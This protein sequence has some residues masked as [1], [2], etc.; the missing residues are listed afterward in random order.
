MINYNSATR[1]RQGPHKFRHFEKRNKGFT[2]VIASTLAFLMVFSLFSANISSIVHLLEAFAV[3]P[4]Y[5]YAGTTSSPKYRY[6]EADLTLYD[7]KTNTE[8]KSDSNSDNNAYDGEN[9]NSVF[10]KALYES[11]YTDA[12]WNSGAS[13]RW[14]LYL[15]L[16]FPGQKQGNQMIKDSGNTYHYSIVANSEAAS[17]TSGAALG[18][19]D[20]ELHGG[21]I[22][23]GGGKV[24]L[25]YFDKEFLTAPLSS[26]LSKSTLKG[27]G[28]T[29]RSST[30][31]GSVLENQKFKFI[32]M[33]DGYYRYK[34]T[35]DALSRSGSTYT[36]GPGGTYQDDLSWSGHSARHAF[37]PWNYTSGH[38]GKFGYGAKFDIKFT[39][40]STGQTFKRD[41]NGNVVIN[42]T[43]HQP[44]Y[45]NDIK[46]TFSGDDDVWVFIDDHLVLDVGGA[47][48]EVGGE[49]CFKKG[50][51]YAKTNY[52]KTTGYNKQDGNA[53][54]AAGIMLYRVM[55]CRN[56]E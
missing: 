2:G 6:Y 25:P 43:T 56:M 14:P 55:N 26:V 53:S 5:Y 29:D 12:V 50:A 34:S 3:D 30:T 52:I 54:V 45:E 39:M 21:D 16:Q 7:Y 13:T 8:L 46:F 42:S 51:A 28:L 35:E 11:G 27:E 47:H 24:I 22:T 1:V 37:F 32:K 38:K 49:I 31:L 15:G 9:R 44:E 36:V 41:T 18:L 17:G 10:N 40:S 23:Q 20:S 4:T 33:S 19:V 48:G